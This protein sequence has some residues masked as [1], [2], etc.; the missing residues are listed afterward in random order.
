M[1]MKENKEVP[2]M[3]KVPDS[4]Q[5]EFE[6]MVSY[7]EQMTKEER[8]AWFASLKPADVKFLKEIDGTTYIVRALFR[9][10]GKESLIGKTERLLLQDSAS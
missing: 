2:H 8:L 6:E 10:D 4:V 7:L 5:A 1:N 9:K 3:I